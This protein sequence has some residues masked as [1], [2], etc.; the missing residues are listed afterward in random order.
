MYGLHYEGFASDTNGTAQRGGLR[1]EPPQHHHYHPAVTGTVEFPSASIDVT[2]MGSISVSPSSMPVCCSVVWNPTVRNK[3]QF[4]PTFAGLRWTDSAA[5][6]KVAVEKFGFTIA[7]MPVSRWLETE[8]WKLTFH[9]NSGKR[10]QRSNFV[11]VESGQQFAGTKLR[12]R[13]ILGG[14]VLAGYSV[15]L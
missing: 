4:Q 5:E 1:A 8:D 7:R 3:P 9:L 10:F 13:N 6:A 11:D 14:N 2:G 12:V 15:P